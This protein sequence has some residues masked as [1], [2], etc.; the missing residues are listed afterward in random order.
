MAKKQEK[1][2]T[3][4][5]VCEDGYHGSESFKNQKEFE[6]WLLA[7]EE[8]GVAPPTKESI[9]EAFKQFSLVELGF[10]Q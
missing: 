1:L 4:D 7:L 8:D 3:I 6:E 10:E 9:S 2:V 5:Y